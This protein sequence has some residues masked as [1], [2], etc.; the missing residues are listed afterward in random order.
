MD[1]IRKKPDWKNRFPSLSGKEESRP[2]PSGPVSLNGMDRV[3]A[4]TPL[5]KRL[6]IPGALCVVIAGAAVWA[7]SGPGG[8]VYRV[9]VDQLTI[10][11]VSK[12]PFEDF[13]AVRG[14]V[15][16][17]IIDYLTTAQGGTV[18]EVLVEDGA[19]VKKGQ[20]LIVLSNPALQLEVAAQQLAFEQTR[21]KYQHD[22]LDIDHEISRLK[23]NLIR[24]KILLDGKA[25]A[26]SIYKQE[27]D[28]YDYNVKM[29]AA[30]V[31]SGDVEQRVRASQLSQGNSTN[32]AAGV[33]ANAQV[34]A[35]TVRA[36]MD[37]QLSAL[38]AEVGQ[39]KAQGAVLGQVNSADR[40]KLTADVDEFYLGRVNPGQETLFSI[41]GENFKAEV[42]KVYPQVTNGT[43]KVDFH[44]DGKAPTGIHVG[45]AVDLRVE[46][47]GASDAVMLPNGPFYQDTGGNWVFVV[48]PDGRSASKRNV[49]LGRRNPQFVEVVDGLSPGEKVIVSGYEAYQKMDRVEFEKASSGG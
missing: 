3:V 37:G 32:A 34:E 6:L 44:F 30:T 27:Q 39:A 8:T 9:P 49:R 13:I 15:A 7:L 48:A 4:K 12:G 28:D 42:A 5:W 19:S 31:A 26:P 41:D 40:F 24:D 29:R 14:A 2:G 35:L 20:P 11:T 22:I 21:F 43:F 10:G 33:V 17:L 46:L 1:V 25:I 16:P 38:D 36:P 47:G 45:Q 23:N 18:K